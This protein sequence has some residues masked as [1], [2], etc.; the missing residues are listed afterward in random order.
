MKNEITRHVP[1]H[2]APLLQ[3]TPSGALKLIAAWNGL[4]VETQI[5]ILEELENARFPA[6]LSEKIRTNAIE[7][8]NPYVR[9]LAARR[10]YFSRDESD[11]RRALRLRIEEDTDTLVRYSLIEAN[12]TLFDEYLADPVKFFSLPHVAR[13]AKIRCLQGGGT[14]I[15]ALI[16]HALDHQLK[17][18]S[19]TEIEIYEILSDYVNKPEFK[20]YYISEGISYDGYGEYLDEKDIEALWRLVPILPDGVSHLLIKN[21]PFGAGLSPRIPDDV[22][23]EMSD[24]QLTTLFY[25]PGIR[26]TELRKKIFFETDEKRDQ[27]KNAAMSQAFD[28]DYEEFAEILAKPEAEKVRSLGNLAVMA[29]D[30][31]VCLYDV[32]HDVLFTTDVGMH[33]RWEDAAYAR[34]SIEEKLSQLQGWVRDRQICELRLYRLAKKAVPWKRTER[35]YPP[36]DELEFMADSIITGDTWATFMAFSEE[37]A[38]NGWRTKRLEKYLPRIAEIQGD[39][40]TDDSKTDE[41]DAMCAAQLENRLEVRLSEVISALTTQT[42][43]KD[44]R[45]IDALSELPAH[46]I[47]FHE[48]IIRLVNNFESSNKELRSAQNRQ[49]LLFY[50][51]IV[52]LILV[53][54]VM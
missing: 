50:I 42:A 29:R 4:S 7:S 10:F 18:G 38:R 36:R 2:I 34:N 8:I 20:S 49:K 46:Q 19:V 39:D 21:L 5:L 14:Q 25:R 16:S 35:G 41:E 48:K 52:L 53:L 54:C 1:D 15:G 51:V 26:L 22:L 11:E 13:L 33:G 28:L 6:Y 24:R 40:T 12:S 32:I 44:T 43:E 37:W 31:S 45:L 47:D 30:L 27:V 9:Y 3:P 17:D 23:S